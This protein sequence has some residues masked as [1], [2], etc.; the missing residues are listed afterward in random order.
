M[1]ALLPPLTEALQLRCSGY[2]VRMRGMFSSIPP[3][4][5]SGMTARS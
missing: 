5:V 4:G 1:A 2:G 3:V